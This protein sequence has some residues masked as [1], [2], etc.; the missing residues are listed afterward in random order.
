MGDEYPYQTFYSKIDDVMTRDNYTCQVC[1]YYGVEANDIV[2]TRCLECEKQ[3][4]SFN[5]IKMSRIP[6]PC[7]EK[8]LQYRVCGECPEFRENSI[9]YVSHSGLLVHHLDGNK[10]NQ[11]L[12]NLVTVCTS[13][14][15]RLH[16][17]GRILQV[18]KVR[19]QIGKLSQ[20][21]VEQTKSF[22]FS[23][24][25]ETSSHEGFL[26]G[27]SGL[28]VQNGWKVS[29]EYPLSFRNVRKNGEIEKRGG[30]IDLHASL[31]GKKIAVEFDMGQSLRF[32]NVAKLLQSKA[33]MAIGIVGGS[34]GCTCSSLDSNKERIQ[35]VMDKLGILDKSILLLI[36]NER[37][38]AS[39]AAK[40]S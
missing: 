26:L 27:L 40:G 14:H 29:R 37:K 36:V 38:S 20:D 35:Y 22:C 12:E 33:D 18:E 28:L 39:I 6:K 31:Q 24:E 9:E 34:K 30:G 16:H 15:R 32:R 2:I 8:G 17:R 10:K 23:C 19:E 13:C 1:G 5:P 21:I 3:G 25:M 4:F 11:E 7:R